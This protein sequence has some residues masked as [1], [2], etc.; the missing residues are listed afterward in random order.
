MEAE[1]RSN[2]QQVAMREEPYHYEHIRVLGIRESPRDSQR[3]EVITSSTA[4]AQ[5]AESSQDESTQETDSQSENI[6]KHNA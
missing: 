3:S 2:W 6:S 5:P 4:V 1:H